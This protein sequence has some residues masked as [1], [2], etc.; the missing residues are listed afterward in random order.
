M[1]RARQHTGEH[2]EES[3]AVSL[4]D[5]KEGGL[6]PLEGSYDADS[7]LHGNAEALNQQD[8]VKK[9]I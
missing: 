1:L 2:E 4:A 6:A 5:V 9:Q 7:Q 8:Q 3:G